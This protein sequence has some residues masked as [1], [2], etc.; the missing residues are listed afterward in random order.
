MASLLFL[1][2]LV[3]CTVSLVLTHNTS[4]AITV[5]IAA[6]YVSVPITDIPCVNIPVDRLSALACRCGTMLAGNPAVEYFYSTNTLVT[7][8]K[9]LFPRETVI[10]DGIGTLGG[11]RINET[12][13]GASAVMRI[14]G[15]SLSDLFE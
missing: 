13:M 3:L 6:T 2:T 5:L 15:S 10:L 11:Q 1:G 14:L 7:D 4:T 8:T 9:E 12:I